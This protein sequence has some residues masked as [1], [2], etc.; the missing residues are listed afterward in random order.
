MIM[1]LAAILILGIIFLVVSQSYDSS[2]VR[3]ENYVAGSEGER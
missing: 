3:P 1:G 2:K